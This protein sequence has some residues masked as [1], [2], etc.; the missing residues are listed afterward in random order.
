[1]EFKVG[2]EVTLD[3]SKMEFEEDLI[4]TQTLEVEYNPKLSAFIL[5]NTRLFQPSL[6]CELK[7]KENKCDFTL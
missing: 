2:G 1:M 4:Y 7:C 6:N 5:S 3:A